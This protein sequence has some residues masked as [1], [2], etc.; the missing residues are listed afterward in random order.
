MLLILLL[1]FKRFK[2]TTGCERNETK[3]D[4]VR[5]FFDMHVHTR[6]SRNSPIKCPRRRTNRRT[7]VPLLLMSL[8]IRREH[9]PENTFTN[10]K[11][12]FEAVISVRVE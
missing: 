1:L 7:A 4:L 8:K 5:L 9:P 3:L 10:R 2:D 6:F 11:T 12:V